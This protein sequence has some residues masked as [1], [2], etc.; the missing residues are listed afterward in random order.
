MRPRVCVCLKLRQLW[1]VFE[2]CLSI[3][4][5]GSFTV[6]SKMIFSLSSVMRLGDIF[7]LEWLDN[8]P[9]LSHDFHLHSTLPWKLHKK[10]ST[11]K[12]IRVI[13]TL[14]VE[15]RTPP[16]VRRASPQTLF[17][18]FVLHSRPFVCSCI[19]AATE[20]FWN[21]KAKPFRNILTKLPK[22]KGG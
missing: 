18:V 14:P 16:D 3:T 13:T 1:F 4:D 19:W 21:K 17:F 5:T 10:L 22:G 12:L 2:K 6:L 9:Q 11:L 15:P 8:H 20:L 7:D